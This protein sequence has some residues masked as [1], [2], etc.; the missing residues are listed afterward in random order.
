MRFNFSGKQDVYI[1][2]AEKYRE[3]IK[4][5]L[6]KNGDKLPSIR[7]AASELG[8]NPNTMARAYALLEDEGYISSIP[9]KG[10]YVTYAEEQNKKED[11]NKNENVLL[12]CN[13]VIEELKSKGYS[14]EQILKAIEEVYHDQH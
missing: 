7:T 4:L 1:E 3:Y 14:K 13:D 11:T 6:I 5:G 8:I 9:K 12:P 10:I 2:V